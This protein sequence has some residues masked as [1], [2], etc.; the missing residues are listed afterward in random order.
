MVPADARGHAKKA[1]WAGIVV[2]PAGQSKASE[3]P[4]FPPFRHN[5]KNSQVPNIFARYKP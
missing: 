2:S 5:P 3:K 4:F 1:I